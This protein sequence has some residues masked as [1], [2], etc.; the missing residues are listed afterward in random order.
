VPAASRSFVD[1]HEEYLVQLRRVDGDDVDVAPVVTMHLVREA[2]C[3]EPDH[4]FQEARR[5]YL[6]PVKPRLIF[7]DKVDARI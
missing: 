3:S 1:W 4:I 6:R 7:E 2:A 5:L